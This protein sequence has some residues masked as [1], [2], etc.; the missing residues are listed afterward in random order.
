[1]VFHV[2]VTETHRGGGQDGDRIVSHHLH[3]A[4]AATGK[5]LFV[6]VDYYARW[7]HEANAGSRAGQTG[8]MSRIRRSFI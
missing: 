3:E 6:H 4:F 7:S 5:F 8:N 2:P 1:V